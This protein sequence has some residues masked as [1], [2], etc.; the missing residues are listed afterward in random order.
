MFNSKLV[1]HR[2]WHNVIDILKGNTWCTYCIC[3]PAIG[4]DHS[5]MV[6]VRRYRNGKVVVMDVKS[7][8]Q[9][10]MINRIAKIIDNGTM[11]G[12]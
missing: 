4:E 3:D 7:I 1:I 11:M 5:A 8:P 9:M 10:P 2:W 6:T 12:D